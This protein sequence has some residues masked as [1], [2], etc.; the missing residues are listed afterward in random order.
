VL[1]G[2]GLG[3]IV[4]S[5]RIRHLARTRAHL[6][7]H[8]QHPDSLVLAFLHSLKICIENYCLQQH[9]RHHSTPIEMVVSPLS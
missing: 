6:L 4:W 9:G 2:L 3:L 1:A 7:A 5:F 8:R